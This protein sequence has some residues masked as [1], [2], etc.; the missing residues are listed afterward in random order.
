MEY[1]MFTLTG[2]VR[3]VLLG[4]LLGASLML[5]PHQASA[6]TIIISDDLPTLIHADGINTLIHADGINTLITG[7][8]INTDRLNVIGDA[9]EH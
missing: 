3:I 4:L 2:K 1:E 7:D 8:G 5:M 9:I 6:D